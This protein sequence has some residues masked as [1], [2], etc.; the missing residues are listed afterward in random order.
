MLTSYYV[1]NRV[2]NKNKDE[3]PY[4][5]WNERKSSLYYM[6]TW[7]CLVKINVPIPKKRE[8]SHKTMDCVFL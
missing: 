6:S 4:D 7:G 1:P 3:T 5:M 2:P 8:L